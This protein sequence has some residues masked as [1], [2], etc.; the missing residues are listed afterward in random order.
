MSFGYLKISGYNRV[1]MVFFGQKV[2]VNSFNA[3]ALCDTVRSG[4]IIGSQEHLSFLPDEG[5]HI[6]IFTFPC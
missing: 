1:G 5:E 6:I 4:R 2:G 3:D